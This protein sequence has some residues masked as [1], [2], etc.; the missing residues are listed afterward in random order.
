ME[1]RMAMMRDDP[2]VELTVD[3]NGVAGILAT[4]FAAEI[5]ASPGQC[6]H[7]ATVS[8]VGT[9]RAY[10]RG[11][12][13]VLRCPACAEVVIRIAETPTA[14]VV[15]LTGARLLRLPRGDAATSAE[16]RS[17]ES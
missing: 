11:P 4:V 9:L 8:L 15:D 5:T 17:A 6:A 2:A 14:I 10:V 1:E 7:C 16:A 12:G 3:G 13:I